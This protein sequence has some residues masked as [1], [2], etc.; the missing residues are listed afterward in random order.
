MLP[1]RQEVHSELGRPQRQVRRI[2]TTNFF[3]PQLHIQ[4]SQRR[5]P[6][7]EGPL[8]SLCLL[9]MSLGSPSLDRPKAQRSRIL[10]LLHF[11]ALAHGRKWLEIRHIR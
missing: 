4:G 8:P 9:R 1:V 5:V 3:L 2:Q 10:H 7:R 11:R 6:S